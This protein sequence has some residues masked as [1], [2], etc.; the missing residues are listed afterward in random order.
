[1]RVGTIKRKRAHLSRS[2]SMNSLTTIA[3]TRANM[4]RDDGMRSAVGS[5]QAL[6]KRAR[7]NSRDR[8]PVNDAKHDRHRQFG[9]ARALEEQIFDDL[10][11]IAPIDQIPVPL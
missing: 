6:A 3:A 4:K 11:V 1:M 7:G 5:V 9:E 8:E 10:D 2:S